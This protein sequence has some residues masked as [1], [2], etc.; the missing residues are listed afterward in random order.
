[1]LPRI[2][3]LANLALLVALVGPAGVAR[4]AAP[5]RAYVSASARDGDGTKAHPYATLGAALHSGART[6]RVAA[7]RYPE[8]VLLAP[9]QTL[10]GEEGSVLE[11]GAEGPALIASGGS[12]KRLAI[13]SRAG[14]GVRIRGEV[15]FDSVEVSAAGAVGVAVEAGALTWRRGR[16]R[17]GASAGTGLSLS[18]GTGA[19]LDGVTVEGPF[20]IGVAAE[21]ARLQL[22]DVTLQGCALGVRL[23]GNRARLSGVRIDRGAQVGVFVGEGVLEAERLSVVG[24][25]YG[26]LA[27]QGARLTLTELTLKENLRAGLAA[28]GAT[29]WVRGGTVSG[30][31]PFGGIQLTGST[32]RLERVEVR[33]SQ[34]EGVAV[35]GGEVTLLGVRVEGVVDPA[36]AEGEGILV[37]RGRAHLK[38]VSVSNV[39]GLGV[40]VAEHG[41]VDFGRLT[42]SSCAAGAVA[43]EGGARVRGDTLRLAHPPNQLIAT[44]Q[45]MLAVKK[46]VL[47]PPGALEVHCEA[48]AR[49]KLGALL[50]APAPDLACL[51]VSAR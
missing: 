35:I 41:E 36:G 51:S 24:H 33:Q 17:G 25:E 30:S 32:G 39:S 19:Q 18:P 42:L 43:S 46:V 20:R 12:V 5:A 37:R 11:G 21:H 47:A 31:G 28:Q 1:V 48:D 34:G 2:P 26:L 3:L 29:L 9:G 50:G 16:L 15:R 49:V 10:W 13:H 40:Y 44:R 7:G 27:G 6:I 4:A 45:G 22:T 14:P 8:R 23:R 38:D